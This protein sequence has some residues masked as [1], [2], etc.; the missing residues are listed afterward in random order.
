[1]KSL[2]ENVA[3]VGI[4][5]AG[6]NIAYQ[7]EKLG[8]TTVHINSSAQDESAISNAKTIMHLEGYNGCA[9]D[10]KKAIEAISNNQKM[11]DYLSNLKEDII[12]I[13]FGAGGGTGSGISPALA[14]ILAD[15]TDKTICCIVA[16]PDSS[17]DLG[18]QSNAYQCVKE[19]KEIDTIGCTLFVDNNKIDKKS[20]L[21]AKIVSLLDAFISDNS[22][23][24]YG[25]VDEE[26]KRTLLA[27]NGNMII[28]V[29][30][31]DTSKVIETITTNNIFAPLQKDNSCEYIAIINSK[32]QGIDKNSLTQV[33][34]VPKRTFIGYGSTDTI[35]AISGLEYPLDHIVAIGQNA[36]TKNSERKINKTTIELDDLGLEDAEE[37]KKPEKKKNSRE[38][39]L[40]FNK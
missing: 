13:A 11:I 20:V 14:G 32:N 4:G 36:K 31:N 33:V 34:G 5:G 22:V 19:L 26:E 17:E 10:R 12:V 6:T 39:L 27:Q 8:Y 25:N 38:A 29:G 15:E 9:G 21:N 18:Y 23:S 1:M 37:V 16:L 3:I 35:V 2:K 7:F 24:S 28:T 40:R 30:D